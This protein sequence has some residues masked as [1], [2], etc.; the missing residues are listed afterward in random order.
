M[1]RGHTGNLGP[2]AIPPGIG[3][4][5]AEIRS[6]PHFSFSQ[7]IHW[8]WVM[9]NLNSAG[10]AEWLA[11]AADSIISD[12]KSTM[13]VQVSDAIAARR[14]SLSQKLAVASG[15]AAAFAGISAPQVAEA[16]I[17]QS[18]TLPRSPP[19]SSGSNSWDVDGDGTDD[20]NLMNIDSSVAQLTELGAAQFVAPSSR[21]NRGFAKLSLGFDV[22]GLMTGGFKFLSNTQQSIRMTNN[23][24]I[25]GN[26]GG[27]GWAIGDI[28]YFG[29]KFSSTSGVHY[30]WGQINIHGTTG[31]FAA[32]QGYTLTEAYYNTTPDA[33][34]QVGDTGGSPSSVPEIDP[35]SA[36]SVLSLVMGSLAMLERR[37]LR[38]AK[39]AEGDAT[40]SA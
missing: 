34:I 28:G 25:G 1:K 24:S 16:G 7:K 20:F 6:R 32:G 12:R 27:Q 29:F 35:A 14:L 10:S 8:D 17:V 37:R 15:A 33:S 4:V 18:M 30:G 38:R 11:T 39:A 19:A 40:V 21:T 13:T 5:L 9:N 22:G 31:G 23:G 26:V 36:G 3:Q 2:N